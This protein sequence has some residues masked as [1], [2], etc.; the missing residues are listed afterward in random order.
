MWPSARAESSPGFEGTT[1]SEVTVT[2]PGTRAQTSGH[3]Y[4][5]T[6]RD[7]LVSDVASRLLQILKAMDDFSKYVQAQHQLS[8]P[9]LWALWEVREAPNMTMSELAARMFLHPS[10][11]SGIVDRLVRR[12]LLT[13]VEDPLDR[14]A[15]RLN[16]TPEGEELLRRAPRPVRPRLIDALREAPDDVLVMV[17]SVFESMSDAIRSRD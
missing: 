9:Q 13:R 14:R 11:V 12:E 2:H 17:R 1:V 16:L 3:H 8:G 4:P 7:H 15:Y 10:T 5:L 6:S